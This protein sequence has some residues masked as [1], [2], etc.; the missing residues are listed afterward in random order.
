MGIHKSIKIITIATL[1]LTSIST[2]VGARIQSLQTLD[3]AL[4]ILGLLATTYVV[5][6]ATFFFIDKIK[7]DVI[8]IKKNYWIWVIL[9]VVAVPFVFARIMLLIGMPY[10]LLADEANRY[11]IIVAEGQ[12]QGLSVLWSAFFHYLDSGN[13]HIT[14]EGG[15]LMSA[16]MSVC[17]ILFFNGLL[18]STMLSWTARRKEQW[19][20]GTSA[21]H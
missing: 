11:N 9:L 2:C 15:R 3:I 21:I 14:G 16:I 6:F 5:Y 13:Q 7:R 12:A 19:D 1:I 8:L 20:N 17:G 4:C 18:V 10:A